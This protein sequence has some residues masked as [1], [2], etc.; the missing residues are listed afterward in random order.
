MIDSLIFVSIQPGSV[1]RRFYD[2]ETTFTDG[3]KA[4]KPLARQ[5]MRGTENREEF[6]A[7]LCPISLLFCQYVQSPRSSLMLIESRNGVRLTLHVQPGAKRA[8][9]VGIH[10]DALKI[11]VQ[12]PPVDGKANKDIASLVA[13]SF[14]LPERA[15]TII[16]GH[17]AR[18]KTVELAGISLNDARAKLDSLIAKHR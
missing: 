7:R 1:V 14:D 10:G 6:A 11:A 17:S 13:D 15:V 5:R 4:K 8:A 9:I 3:A 18:R 12:A 2:A 16:A